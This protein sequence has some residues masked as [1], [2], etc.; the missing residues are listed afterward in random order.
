MYVLI[1]SMKRNVRLSYAKRI[2]NLPQGCIS[3]IALH[4]FTK[5][6]KNTHT[7]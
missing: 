6:Y 5:R 1:I 2:F 4:I 3:N 7:R